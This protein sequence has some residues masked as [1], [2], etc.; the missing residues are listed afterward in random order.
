[1]ANIQNGI[2][3][4][5]L[6]TFLIIVFTTI[7][8]FTQSFD[9]FYEKNW[10]FYTSYTTINSSSK[11]LSLL[12]KDQSFGFWGV[13]NLDGSF[14]S[15]KKYGMSFSVK[16]RQV[17]DLMFLLVKILTDKNKKSFNTTDYLSDFGFLPN[18]RFGLLRTCH[19]HP[20]SQT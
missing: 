9:E 13:L 15:S 3:L 10:G 18:L 19:C 11:S 1:M 7:E 20:V 17:G 16:Q 8:A 14:A 4:K 5:R 12:G 2:K 6:I